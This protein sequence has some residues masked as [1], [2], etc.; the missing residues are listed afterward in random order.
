[1]SDLETEGDAV[2]TSATNPYQ[3]ALLWIGAIAL[4][5]GGV[6][7]IIGITEGTSASSAA[8]MLG[9]GIAGFGASSLLLWLVV[10]ALTWKKP[11]VESTT[12]GLG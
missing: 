12:D 9:L 5:L 6:I 10:S 1:M 3:A 2:F 4:F 8:S 7:A 11:H